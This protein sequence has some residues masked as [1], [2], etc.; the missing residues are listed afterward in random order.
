MLDLGKKSGKPVACPLLRLVINPYHAFG[1]ESVLEIRKPS[2]T[3]A[4]VNRSSDQP[5]L[6][7]LALLI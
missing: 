6:L 7:L 1:D 5:I 3:T 4:S 2:D